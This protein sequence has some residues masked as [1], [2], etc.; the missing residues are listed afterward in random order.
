MDPILEVTNLT[1]Q[2]EDFTLRNV[3]LTVPKG[4]ITGLF[5]PSGAGKTTLMKLIANQIAASSGSIRVL[6]LSYADREKEIKNRIGYVP[7]EPSFYS[8]RSVRGIARF[9]SRFFARWDCACFYRLLEESRISPHKKVNHLSRGQKTLL[10][11][12]IALSHEPELLLFDEPTSGLDMVLRRTVLSRLRDFVADGEKTVVISSHLTHSL[13]DIAEFIQFLD[14]GDLVLE[15][16]KDDLLDSWKWIHFKNGSLGPDVVDKLND[17]ERQ[18]FG[19]RGLTK[20]FPAIRE[21]LA[22]GIACGD[23]KVA[24]AKLDDILIALLKGA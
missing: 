4:C 7:Q 16:G 24:N 19:S 9:V 15:S 18:P 8:A 17:V 21:Q 22:A 14:D 3:T 1:K 6:G 10:S 12:A 11:I 23:V 13:D 5:G 20:D 2:Y